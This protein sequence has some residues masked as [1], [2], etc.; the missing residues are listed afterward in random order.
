MLA[1]GAT[2]RKPK[3]GVCVRCAVPSAERRCSRCKIAVY[4]SSLCQRQDWPTHK[5]TCGKDVDEDDEVIDVEEEIAAAEAEKVAA[6][7]AARSRGAPGPGAI[8]VLETL[9]APSRDNAVL[10]TLKAPPP[11]DDHARSALR[12]EIEKRLALARAEAALA[13]AIAETKARVQA[14][15]STLSQIPKTEDEKL[16]D[17]AAEEANAAVLDAATALGRPHVSA[18]VKAKGSKKSKTS[19]KAKSK[20][21]ARGGARRC[22]LVRGREMPV[23]AHGDRTVGELASEALALFAKQYPIFASRY[24]PDTN[25][26]QVRVSGLEVSPPVPLTDRAEN[27]SEMLN[28]APVLDNQRGGSEMQERAF[29]V[30]APVMADSIPNAE[31]AH[32]LLLLDFPPHRALEGGALRDEYYRRTDGWIERSL[33]EHKN[34]MCGCSKVRRVRELE[35]ELAHDAFDAALRDDDTAWAERRP[36]YVELHQA[37]LADAYEANML[38]PSTDDD[39]FD[40]PRATT[41]ITPPPGRED[42]ADAIKR[43]A[44]CRMPLMFH[45]CPFLLE[46]KGVVLLLKW[47]LVQAG[48][49]EN[50]AD[51]DEDVNSAEQLVFP[52]CQYMQPSWVTGSGDSDD[53]DGGPEA[54][55]F[56]ELLTTPGEYEGMWT[57]YQP[58][59]KPDGK[60]LTHM[61]FKYPEALIIINPRARAAREKIPHLSP[62]ERVWHVPGCLPTPARDSDEE[63]EGS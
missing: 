45:G 29:L 23:G 11:D 47:F 52:L 44:A 43:E 33:L 10:E 49:I 9:K 62:V 25:R 13:N 63:E 51:D 57:E 40:G 61:S 34:G 5:I 46:A 1:D 48:V 14:H 8:A 28:R 20:A 41:F 37:L 39:D 55:Q 36:L 60:L 19:A 24:P 53:E 12:D 26:I 21:A 3:T 38:A 15:Y 56:L 2:A 50:D 54:M 35:R 31:F 27:V 17:A 18:T 4:C 59:A 58:W 6:N 32:G 42:D 30:I 16:M 22:W 7:E